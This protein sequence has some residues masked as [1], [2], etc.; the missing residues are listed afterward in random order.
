MIKVRFLSGISLFLLATG[1][2]GCVEKGDI[3]MSCDHREAGQD[4]C[5]ERLVADSSP[6]N[7]EVIDFRRACGAYISSIVEAPCP[8]QERV[9]G[10]QIYEVR[11][12]MGGYIG[13][14]V[15]YWYYKPKTKDDVRAICDEYESPFIDI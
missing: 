12:F 1:A 11:E 9:A 10:C 5:E 4:Y 15:K 7:Q 14:D 2:L 6:D 8:T 13:K 3:V